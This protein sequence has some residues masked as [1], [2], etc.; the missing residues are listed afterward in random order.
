[1]V[2]AKG[3]GDTRGYN[4]PLGTHTF[5][6]QENG[7]IPNSTLPLIIRQ[8]AIPPSADDP[9]K[10]FETTFARNGWTGAW[11][12]G[13]Y[14]FHHYHSTAHEVLGIACGSATVRFGGE[15]GETFGLST[16]DVV[17]IP[18][19]VAHALINASDDLLVVGAYADGRDYDLLR[20]D[21]NALAAARTRI[22]TVPL[23]AMDPV[24]GAQGPLV[25]LW[26]G[27]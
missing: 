16:G 22:T 20:E 9:A 10:T 3:Y 6:F 12:N 15:G 26:T 25:K 4:V 17:V 24:D 5:V 2:Q 14:D 27:R 1:M 23:P 7:G 21:P 8:G 11:R 19:G 18:A 13:I